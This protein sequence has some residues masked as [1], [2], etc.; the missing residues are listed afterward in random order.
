MSFRYQSEKVAFSFIVSI[1]FLFRVF[2]PSFDKM[3]VGFVPFEEI[4]VAEVD[5]V[6]I[7]TN[8]MEVVHIKLNIKGKGTC[9]TKDSNFPCLKYFLSTSFSNYC[10]LRITSS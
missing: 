5:A 10:W 3:K 2:F 9:L 7:S 4:F 8:F 1:V 6:L